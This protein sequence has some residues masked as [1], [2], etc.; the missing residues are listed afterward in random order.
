MDRLLISHP[1]DTE[2]QTYPPEHLTAEGHLRLK[3]HN[4]TVVERAVRLFGLRPDSEHA[5][6]VDAL[7]SL[8][9]FGKVTPQF[10][11]YIRPDETYT[12]SNKAE[13]NH[14]RLGALA[15]WFVLGRLEAPPQDRLAA[16]LAVARHHQAL[17]NA[18][19][20]TAEIL[21]DVFEEDNETTQ[22]QLNAVDEYWPDAAT[23]LLQCADESA[24]WDVF[25]AEVETD[26][27]NAYGSLYGC[28]L[29]ANQ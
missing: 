15:T 2:H 19:Q 20:Y 9:D 23:S 18:A 21:A 26:R 28:L 25:A 11:A 22:A 14:A 16:T 29:G 8:H 13:K 5:R 24:T 12:W 27:L 6:Y 4:T 7:A 10:Q 1:A 17:P 3:A